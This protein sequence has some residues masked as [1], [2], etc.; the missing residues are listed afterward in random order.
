MAAAWVVTGLACHALAAPAP[1]AL[2]VIGD[3][4]PEALAPAGDAARARGL[5]VARENANCVLCHEIPDAA[6]PFFG[7][8]GPSLAH[9]GSRLSPAQI[10]LRIVDAMRVNPDTIMPSYYRTT[11]LDRVAPQYRG[12]T[13]LS[14]Q[15]VEDLVAYLSAL[16]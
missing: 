4:I 1:G 13:V 3:G 2:R 5:L 15:D 9:V 12:K 10:R 8:V 6:L 11:G 7:N 16:Q 14:A